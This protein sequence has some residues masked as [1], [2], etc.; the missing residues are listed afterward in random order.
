MPT[1]VFKFGGTSVNSAEKRERII[2]LS[3]REILKGNSVVCVVSAM[4]RSGDPYATDTLLS[5][6]PSGREADA[7]V[8]DLLV[9]CGETISACVL[10]DCFKTRGLKVFPMTALQAGIRTNGKFGDARI[11]DID[12]KMMR[13]KLKEGYVVIVTGF[14]GY[15]ETNELTTLGRGGSDTSAI[16]V[17]G[18]LGACKVVIYS[19]VP[20]I[21]QA[22]PRVIPTAKFLKTMDFN[23]MLFLAAM[24]AKVLHP[25]A[26]RTAIKYKM[27]FE[28]KDISRDEGSTLIG[29]TGEAVG[30]LF[31]MTIAKNAKV[32]DAQDNAA[33]DVKLTDEDGNAVLL[34]DVDGKN[35]LLKE[36]KGH[37]FLVACCDNSGRLTPP[38][39]SDILAKEGYQA[40][41]AFIE[42]GKAV[43]A[44]PEEKAADAMKTVFSKL[45]D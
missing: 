43:W 16:A 10:A 29:F 40:A 24:G 45:A 28:A 4:G 20:G 22:D 6:L 31:G 35:K 21:A 42:G 44:I 18:A 23:S 32:Y 2:E 8:S 19:D 30:G 12:T 15:S 5:L 14:Q 34:T 36:Y 13:Q 9:G 25:N 1:V 37:Y 39:I 26:I 27:P 41:A 17:G 7:N 11:T 33:G 3:S 38:M